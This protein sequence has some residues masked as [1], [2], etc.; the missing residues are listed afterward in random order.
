MG[1]QS[2]TDLE[3]QPD[4]SSNDRVYR[5]VL[6]IGRKEQR[7]AAE[8]RRRLARNPLYRLVYMFGIAG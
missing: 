1:Y 7:E 8:K 3:K 4:S 2:E 5:V 6:W